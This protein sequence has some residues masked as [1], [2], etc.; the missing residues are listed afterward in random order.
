MS[1]I[2]NPVVRNV[3]FIIVLITMLFL[4]GQVYTANAQE[5]EG[6][7]PGN[8]HVVIFE[9]PIPS[10]NLCGST[11]FLSQMEGTLFPLNLEFG[12]YQEGGAN[13][14]EG[15][16][17]ELPENGNWSING[18][19]GMHQCED[20]GYATELTLT[21]PNSNFGFHYTE[22]LQTMSRDGSHLLRQEI[23]ASKFGII[24]DGSNEVQLPAGDIT[25][26]IELYSTIS[27]Q[28]TN[29]VVEEFS[30]WE[31]VFDY[32]LELPQD[33]QVLSFIVI[34]NPDGLVMAVERLVG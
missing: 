8:M 33:T 31:E 18:T 12:K 22:E 19:W 30:S 24:V 26:Y 17:T 15:T 4:I 20:P 29:T 10:T 25:L 28:R 9:Y 5:F 34:K 11:L 23:N 1:N 14:Y 7:E 13:W 3:L 32:G 2:K 27:G 6:N 16:I 21:W